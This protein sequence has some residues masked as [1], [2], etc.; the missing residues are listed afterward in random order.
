[1]AA[2]SSEALW[3]VY[4]IRCADGSLYAG[5]STDVERR[6]AEHRDASGKGAKYLRG[7]GPLE[8]VC[9]QAIGSRSQALT[10]ESRFRKLSKEQK[11]TLLGRE[12]WLTMLL[13]GEATRTS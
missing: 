12:C 4:I 7:R 11:E 9:A 10:V 2:G 6:L 13:D 3:F 1:M 8:M 5:V